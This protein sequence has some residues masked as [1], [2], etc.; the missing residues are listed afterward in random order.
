MGNILD[1]SASTP[2]TPGAITHNC[3]IS[4]AAT[5]AMLGVKDAVESTYLA[6]ALC[7]TDMSQPST[8]RVSNGKCGTFEAAIS[9]VKGHACIVCAP[10]VS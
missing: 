6:Q 2:Q 3:S 4:T 7:Y 10:G 5:G 8:H 9:T 1:Y